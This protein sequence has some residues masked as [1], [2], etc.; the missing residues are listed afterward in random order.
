M[1][2]EQRSKA[3]SRR[4]TSLMEVVAGLTLMT[5]LIVP[6]TG[7]LSASARLWRQFESGHGSVSNRQTAVLAISDRLRGASKILAIS[8]RQV[9]FQSEA[10]DAQRIY[11][12]RDQIFWEHAGRTD[13]V[14]ENVGGLQMRQ[15]AS[16]RTP[17]EGSL[18]EIRVQNTANSG[19]A[20]TASSALVWVRPTI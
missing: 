18:L 3:T 10:G 15:I 1:R 16:G 5:L 7:L 17:S 4:G 12:S 9:R 11:Q 6:M 19:V 8:N 2:V 14:S 20:N 13:L